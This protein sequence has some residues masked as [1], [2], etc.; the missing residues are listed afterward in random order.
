MKKTPST[1]QFERV[2]FSLSHFCI[3]ILKNPQQM[4]LWTFWLQKSTLETSCQYFCFKANPLTYLLENTESES[5]IAI[6]EHMHAEYLVMKFF[7]IFFNNSKKPMFWKNSPIFW[8][9]HQTISHP[10]H[11]VAQKWKTILL[12]V[13]RCGKTP[14]FCHNHIVF[15]TI[16]C[17]RDF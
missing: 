14:T 10:L 4:T 1:G 2:D 3:L 11:C 15:I 5:F 6:L 13:K 16:V 12:R 9:T 8:F 17:F 7:L